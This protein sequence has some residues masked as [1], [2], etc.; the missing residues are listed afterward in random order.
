M[1]KHLHDIKS[2]FEKVKKIESFEKERI[3]ESMLK[4]HFKNF[5]NVRKFVIVIMF[6][7]TMKKKMK[8]LLKCAKTEVFETVYCMKKQFNEKINN[9]F[10][11][12]ENYENKLKKKLLKSILTTKLLN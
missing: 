12:Y 9:N 2:L 8:K 3:L 5:K 11:M 10:L 7:V 1:S 6:D 4:K